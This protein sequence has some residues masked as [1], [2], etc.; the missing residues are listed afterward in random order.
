MVCKLITASMQ[1]QKTSFNLM[2][3]LDNVI[4]SSPGQYLSARVIQYQIRSGKST[5]LRYNKLVQAIKQK[6]DTDTVKMSAHGTYLD[7]LL[8]AASVK[9]RVA[10]VL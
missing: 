4:S 10:E 8:R 1:K 5:V 6:F 9:E 2:L 7:V 3:K